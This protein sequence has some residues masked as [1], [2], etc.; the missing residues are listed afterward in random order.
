[1]S[2]GQSKRLLDEVREQIR[3]RHYSLATERAYSQ[4]LSE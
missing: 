3:I 4:S 1:L 2:S